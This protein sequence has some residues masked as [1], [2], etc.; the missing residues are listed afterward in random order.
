MKDRMVKVTASEMDKSLSKSGRI[1]LYGINFDFN[2]TE[3]KPDSAEALAEIG[4]L[5]KSNPALKVLIVGHTDSI[6]GF[7]MNKAL[8]QRRAE[9][10]VAALTS[11]FE[12]ASNRLF[13]VGV[14]FAAPLESN[15]SETGRAKNRRVELVKIVESGL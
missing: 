1:A 3:V 9:A 11:R 10:V 5:M 15:E 14:S 12:V 8:S 13:P 4:T 2:K 7:D 6:G